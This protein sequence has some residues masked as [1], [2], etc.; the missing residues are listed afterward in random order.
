MYAAPRIERKILNAKEEKEED[1][2]DLQH[3]SDI[4]RSRQLPIYEVM[5]SQFINVYCGIWNVNVSSMAAYHTSLKKL[6][7]FHFSIR[8]NT[9]VH[10]NFKYL[11][12]R[13]NGH[14]STSMGTQINKRTY[15]HILKRVRTVYALT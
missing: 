10:K 9:N 2:E 7:I 8:T 6:H 12:R 3:I 14:V 4:R 5:R 11:T 15:Q 13:M 1:E